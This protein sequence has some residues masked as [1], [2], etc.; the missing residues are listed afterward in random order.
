MRELNIGGLKVKVPI[1]QGGMGVAISLSGLASA[2]ANQGGIGVISAVGIG[3][4]EPN[5]IKNVHQSNLDSLRTEIRKAKKLSNGVLGV[6]IMMA[7][8]DYE[9][10]LKTAVEEKIDIIFVGA[11][12]LL[13][14]PEGLTPKFLKQTGTKIVPKLS[15][16]RAVGLILKYWD[17]KYQ[18]LPDAFVIEGPK[19]GG[20]LGFNTFELADMNIELSDIIEE[21]V[22]IIKPY[23][24]KY[25]VEIPTIA[26]GG[27]YSGKNIFEIMQKGAKGVKL[28]TRF[29]TTNE[30]DASIEFK[31]SYI[32]CKKE[33]VV[34]IKS[35]V[36]LPGRAIRNGF[37]DD[38]NSGL[39]KPF[40]CYWRCL[41]T[42][43]YKNV[44]YC[45]AQALFNAAN[46]KMSDG[47]AFAGSNA[48]KATKIQSV[49]EVIEELIFEYKLSE[50]AAKFSVQKSITFESNLVMEKD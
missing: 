2:V 16:S 15:S 41:K 49:Q 25:G 31:K 26:A 10:L 29:V 11:G 44:P 14:L 1:I 13:K 43:D 38:V 39:K 28:G 37:I 35:P 4:N 45:I 34:I 32:N 3:M 48:Y 47:F 27:I 24:D 21:T 20:H 50:Q 6:N 5:Y 9:D 22:A 18:V 19:A 7:V 12:L 23:E 17:E 8:T 46:G 30:C 36:G 33:E 42:C 40:K